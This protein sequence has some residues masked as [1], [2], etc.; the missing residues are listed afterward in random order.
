MSATALVVGGTGPTGPYVVQGLCERGFAV[1]MLHTGRHE[2]AEVPAEVEH[3]HADPFDRDVV[4]HALGGRTFDLAV[5][6]YGRL[7]DLAEQLRDRVDRLISIGGG[8]VVDGFGN[9]R[10]L[11]PPGMPVPTLETAPTVDQFDR[12]VRNEKVARMVDTERAVFAAHPSA[13]HVRYPLIYGPHQLLPRE[14]LVVRRILDGRRRIIVADGGL[15]LVSAAY[16]ENAAAA[17][18]LCVDQ[19]DATAGEVLHAGDETTPTVRQV[20][21]IVAAELDREIEIVDLPYE[22]AR[23]SYPLMMRG[24]SFHRFMPPTRL[25]ALGY[26]DRVPYREGLARTVRW[27]VD[28][29]LRGDSIERNLQ[30]PFNYA[31]E[32]ALLAA[33]DAAIGPLEQAAAEADPY[34]VDRYSP[35]QEEDRE[36]RRAARRARASDAATVESTTGR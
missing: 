34:Y 7:R 14:W 24:G 5:V 26:R 13:T 33:W 1:T 6:M 10:D 21:E 8:P 16:V 20:I 2:R 27:L 29:P 4:A 18:L 30:D 36:R 28:N 35:E 22:M 3:V 31:A 15:Q 19:P 25:L 23:P 12:P 9:P 11:S 17:V 32:D